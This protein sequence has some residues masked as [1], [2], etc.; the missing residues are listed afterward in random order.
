MPISSTGNLY[1]I[2]S[3]IADLKP[4]RV[5]D[6][7]VGFGLYGALC[8]Q[9]LDIADGRYEKSRWQAQIRGIESYGEYRTPLWDYVYDEVIIGDALQIVPQCG[10]VDLALLCDVI[11]HFSR[12][13][14]FRLIEK[15]LAIADCLIISTPLVGMFEEN[16]YTARNSNERHLSFW[17]E[18]DF[19]PWLR[20]RRLES[21]TGVFLLSKES[22]DPRVG[23]H[24]GVAYSFRRAL[25]NSMPEPAVRSVRNIRRALRSRIK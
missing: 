2:A 7:G 24:S 23:F 18:Q 6:I 4:R 25:K 15:I 11:E 10:R 1:P 17:T 8:R 21:M 16:E 12:E 20:A 14:G 19:R 22:V 3:F 13:D 5:I 9:I